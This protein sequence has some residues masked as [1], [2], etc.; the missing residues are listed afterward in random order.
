MKNFLHC[1]IRQIASAKAELQHRIT[2]SDTNRSSSGVGLF[3]VKVKVKKAKGR[4]ISAQT[5]DRAWGFQQVNLL[6]TKRNLLCNIYTFQRD[7]QC[8]STDC[9]LMHR[10]QLYMFRTVTV[11]PQELLFRCCMCRLCYAVKTALSDT[12]SWYNVVPAG[13]ISTYHSLH[14]EYLQKKLLRMDRYGPKH[15]Q[16][17]PEY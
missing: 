6:K 12:S 5:L 2:I 14:I 15:V 7:T 1:T 9:L 17:T 8:C 11:H 13:R 16:L 10:C 4:T 3:L